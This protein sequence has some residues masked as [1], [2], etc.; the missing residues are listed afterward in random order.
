MLFLNIRF[1]QISAYI[2]IR[3]GCIR[4]DLLT[5]LYS[6]SKS[7]HYSEVNKPNWCNPLIFKGNFQIWRPQL[8]WKKLAEKD[9]HEWKLMTVDPQERS[10][11]RS[12]VRSAMCAT[13][14]LPGKGPTDVDDAPAP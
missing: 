6:D 7:G 10:T 9:C 4:L 13:S 2:C 11:W 14:Q 3:L 1:R 5:I 8:T 12:G